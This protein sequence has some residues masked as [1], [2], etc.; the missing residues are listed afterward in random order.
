MEKLSIVSIVASYIATLFVHFITIV[1]FL[2]FIR[3]YLCIWFLS[4]KIQFSIGIVVIGFELN[5]DF[6]HSHKQQILGLEFENDAS[7][8]LNSLL[9]IASKFI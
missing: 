7:S 4:R 1:S 5:Q 8:S 9:D 6:L 3:D 2:G